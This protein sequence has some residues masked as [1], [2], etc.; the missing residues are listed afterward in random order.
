PARVRSYAGA[1][2]ITP[3]G[4][5]LGTVCV[6]DT[7]PRELDP[8]QLAGLQSLSRLAVE[9]LEARRNVSR[10]AAVAEECEEAL[11]RAET[12]ETSFSAVF[13]NAAVGVLL[14]S[15]DG[16][17][18]RANGAFGAMLDRDPDD[19]QGMSFASI[20][21]QNDVADDLVLVGPLLAGETNS[22][23]REERYIHQ[24]GG[25]VT[26]VSSTTAIRG[27][28]GR[29]T[30]LLSNVESIEARRR[31][32]QSLLE[33]QSATDAIIT[34]D[35]EGRIVAWNDGAAR[36]FGYTRLQALGQQASML[37]PEEV[38]ARRAEILAEL[39]AGSREDLVGSTVELTMQR[40]DGSQFPAELSLS[41]WQLDGHP[42]VTGVVR[43][44]TERH[45]LHQELLRQ[46]T[47]DALTGVGNRVW[48]TQA[49]AAAL[50]APEQAPLGVLVIEFEGL[51]AVG[52]SLGLMLGDR[53]VVD[54]ANHLGATLRPGDGL[55]RLDNG[56][57]AVLLPAT[58]PA[59][60]S[61]VAQRLRDAIPDHFRVRGSPIAIRALVGVA[62]HRGHVRETR[63]ATSATH[64]LR[65]ATL[66]L[67]SARES[68]SRTATYTV[69]IS[70]RARRR[71]RL[72]GL[73]QGAIGRGELSLVYQPQIDLATARLRAVEA[74]CRWQHP[75]LHAISPA[76]FIPLAEDTGLATELGGWV[77]REACRQ[78]ARW[79]HEL[80]E[81]LR[82]SVNVS[83][84][85][86][87]DSAVTDTL[88][89]VLRAT[90]LSP[91]LLTLEITESVLIRDP[92][93]VHRRL[94]EIRALGVQ[95]AVDDFGTGY[96][97]L[98]ALTRLPVD[99]LKI[100]RSFVAGLPDQ[101]SLAVARSIV[102]LGRAL[103]LRIVAEGIETV[104]QHKAL[105][106][107]DCTLGQGFLF[108]PP[109]PPDAIADWGSRRLRVARESAGPPGGGRAVML[110]GG[111]ASSDA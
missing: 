18:T 61:G 35:A 50:Q 25:L 36:V 94:D 68:S 79:S 33:T 99:E 65:N 26:A 101:A 76:E 45:R 15:L 58:P 32:E 34:A 46:A 14:I 41:S 27:P 48:F 100:D 106:G 87:M 51:R 4:V 96:S 16:L 78:A 102:D 7:R 19:L 59:Q 31:A 63:A 95:T 13:D 104:E 84:H 108:A 85:Q 2:L 23:V 57:F 56:D 9:L 83:A 20:T 52:E 69:E 98:G 103:D 62:H 6:L 109:M 47:S 111:S 77:L 80:P 75:A 60:V 10:I 44:V 82:V 28:G 93:A 30:G 54:V 105:V 92:A 39:I 88:V 64:L 55:A 11:R 1:P 66:A 89:S 67:T 17:I 21:E 73:L 110:L 43:D 53:L 40:Q 70:T 24:D 86:L 97:S 72:H 49:V 37:M 5:M 42:R 74:L 12:N 8:A 22:V 81:P 90:G 29:V 107:L 91:G 71:L 3:D 38:R